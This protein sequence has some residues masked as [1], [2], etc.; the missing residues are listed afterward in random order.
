M[1]R[2]IKERVL[3]LVRFLTDLSLAPSPASLGTDTMGQTPWD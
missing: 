2:I 3:V 1:S